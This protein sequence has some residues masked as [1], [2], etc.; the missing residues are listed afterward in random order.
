[1]SVN[2]T[3]KLEHRV[4]KGVSLKTFITAS[5]PEPFSL[6]E[7]SCN[8][9]TKIPE[10]S[11]ME[12]MLWAAI[13]VAAATLDVSY[14]LSPIYKSTRSL[15]SEDLL[16]IAHSHVGENMTRLESEQNTEP[17]QHMYEFRLLRKWA[18]PSDVWS[19]VTKNSKH[20]FAEVSCIIFISTSTQYNIV[21]AAARLWTR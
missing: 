8:L 4:R 11:E 21:I 9:V 20:L 1:M 18:T 6:I 13:P 5:I 3:S 14:F 2:H 19:A 12:A 16:K 10:G 17:A 7:V 15:L